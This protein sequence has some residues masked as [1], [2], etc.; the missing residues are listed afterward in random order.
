[1]ELVELACRREGGGRENEGE[2]VFPISFSFAPSF[3]SLREYPEI[4]FPLTGGKS[5]AQTNQNL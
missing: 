2:H 5:I 4:V 3:P 1:M